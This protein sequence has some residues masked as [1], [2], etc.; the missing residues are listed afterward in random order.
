M[1]V[2]PGPTKSNTALAWS[3]D[4]RW[5]VAAGSGIGI[6][7]WNADGQA[8]GRHV[9]RG[10]HGGEAMRFC[11]RSG[12]L[13]VSFRTGGVWTYDPE[14]TEERR[15][16][17]VDYLVGHSCLAVSDDGRTVV[18]RRSAVSGHAVSGHR[19]VGHAVADDG[20]L[21]AVWGRPDNV[22]TGRLD[23]TFRPGTDQLFGL[24]VPSTF[25]WVVAATGER[26]GSF[27]S[28]TGTRTV[29][30]WVLS[31]DGNQVAWLCEHAIY[32]QRLD[33][34]APRVLPAGADEY[35]RGLAFHPSGRLLAYTTGPTVRLVNVDAL[36]EVRAY[37][38]GTGKARTV[39]FSLDGLRAAVSAEGGRGWVTVFD[40]EF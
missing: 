38:W 1:R 37:D 17:P 5:V 32:V 14:T 20:A 16:L 10:G 36:T 6:T 29:A 28:A 15:R 25:E 35:R 22:V 23:F 34:P 40:L 2:L 8:P 21:V 19:I 11:P 30:Q 9:L 24:C 26:V 12:R 27:V 13:Y 31:P 4:G 39:A 18:L 3:P 33:E 7:V